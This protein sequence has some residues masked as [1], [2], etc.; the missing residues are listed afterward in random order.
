[1][2]RALLPIALAA[3]RT[4]SHIL[5]GR[6]FERYAHWIYMSAAYDLVFIAAA[7]LLFDYAL[8]E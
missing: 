3:V 1:M 6:P 4:T 8:Q 2:Q 7:V 5:A